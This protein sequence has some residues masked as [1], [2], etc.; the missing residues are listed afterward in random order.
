MMAPIMGS[1]LGIEI[2]L[3]SYEPNQVTPRQMYV[4]SSFNLCFI[5]QVPYQLCP[6][7]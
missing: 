3:T 7:D 4:E 1:V 5:F 6:L 2:D